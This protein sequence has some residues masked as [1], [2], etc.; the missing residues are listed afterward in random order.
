M[1]I[2][3]PVLGGLGLFL[4]GMNIMGTGLE[5]ASGEKL[6]RLIEI[7]TS[8]RLMGVLVGTV[9]TLIM[10]SSSATTIMVVGFVNAGLMNLSQAMGVIMG[11]NIGTTVTAQLIAFDLADIAPLAVAIGVG[12]WLITSK[13]RLKSLAEVLIGFGVL[14][15][16]MDM[17][18][19]GLKPLANNP[20]FSN[21]IASLNNPLLGILVGFGL[22][23]LIQSSSASIGLLQALASLGL[24]DI[25]IAFPILFG[26]NIGT[27]TTALIS[28]VGANKTAKRAAIM[29]FL[30]NLIGTILFVTLLR[31]PIQ[32]IVL[33]I[34]PYDIK[35]QIANAHT[36]FNVINTIILF[37]FANL[38]IKAAEKMIP[39]KD[40]REEEEELIYLDTRIM[41]TPSIALGQVV[42]EIFRMANLVE[43]NVKT[44]YLAFAN[45]DERLIQEVFEKEKTINKLE[46]AIIQYLVDLS[47]KPLTEKQHIQV[48]ALINSIND[49]ERVGDHA[50]NIGELTQV[51]IEN[52]LPFSE[53]AMKELENIFNKTYDAFKLASES[54][55]E[56]NYEKAK[57]TLKLEE[58]V[59][60][61]E[62]KYR[63]NHI[64]RLNR[65]QCTPHSGVI[66]LD[67]LSNLER[68]SDHSSNIALYVL[69][70]LKENR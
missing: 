20:V 13:K 12:I 55:H 42:K 48:N 69:D 9:V 21:M 24:V 34:S 37:P 16:G 32:S 7:L 58:E 52:N 64:D 45:K 62:E 70:D 50:D 65:M 67:F 23:T 2:A 4:Y 49:I 43:N 30:F 27:T 33:K 29:H 10:Q 31:I 26:D 47:N 68:I 28:S 41:E 18:S 51:A 46:T 59:D 6:K 25:R 39:G 19:G 14:F 3:L 40:V 57:E 54:L 53:T 36:L 63:T 66:Y 17:M 44:A 56:V 61:L 60:R 8:N 11:A 35:R 5:K 15:I 1:D 22:T 38:I